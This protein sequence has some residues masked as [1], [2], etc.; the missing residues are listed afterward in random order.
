MVAQGSDAGGGAA[1]WGAGVAVGGAAGGA[2][3]AGVA[4]GAA[5][6]GGGAMLA[7][8]G[9]AAVF[10]TCASS[11]KTQPCCP[12]TQ[13]I[14]HQS[15]ASF[16]AMISKLWLAS[17][18]PTKPKVVPGPLRTLIACSLTVSLAWGAAVAV[19]ALAVTGALSVIG[20]VAVSGA[21]SV[22][23]AVA[24]STG[25]TATGAGVLVGAGGGVGGSAEVGVKVGIRARASLGGR[26][27]VG[28]GPA[29]PKRKPQPLRLMTISRPATVASP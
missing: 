3:G 16:L 2:A 10:S 1:T 6:T 26:V 11:P 17:A 15:L 12:L 23:G 4:V 25:A 9:T 5:A 13:Q 8:T 20:V 22:M 18:L 27:G 14:C 28:S 7:A 19:G 24:G 21:V 29:G